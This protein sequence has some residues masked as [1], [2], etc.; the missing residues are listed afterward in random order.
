MPEELAEETIAKKPASPSKSEKKKRSGGGSKAGAATAGTALS[1]LPTLAVTCHFN[2][3]PMVLF[4]VALATRFYALDQPNSIVFDELHYGRYAGLY[5]KQ[6]FFFDSHPPLGKQLLALA[7]Y[8]GG[9]QGSNMT[10]FFH[11]LREPYNNLS[12]YLFFRFK[13]IKN[14]HVTDRKLVHN[15]NDVSPKN[16]T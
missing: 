16:F 13:Q 3:L 8:L 12:A 15:H 11:S 6:T 1:D 4:G 9:F 7:G 14:G 10:L 5:Q 2:L